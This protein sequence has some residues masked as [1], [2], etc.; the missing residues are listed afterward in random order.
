MESE[1]NWDIIRAWVNGK[2][3]MQFDQWNTPAGEYSLIWHLSDELEDYYGVYV[4]RMLEHTCISVPRNLWKE[5]GA[6]IDRQ[7][8][9]G[10][11]VSALTEAEFWRAALG[12]RAQRIIGPAY[13]GFLDEYH[14][15]PA[16]SQG[17]RKLNL[18]DADDEAALR[19]FLAACPPDDWE[20]SAILFKHQSVMGLERNGALVA[21]ASAPA[22][23][24][25]AAEIY[26]V[27]V[28]TL[29]A[30]RGTGAGLAV[31]SALT[32]RIITS[33]PSMLLHYQTLRANLP[34]VAIAQRLGFEELATSLA[35]RLR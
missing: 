21:V 3:G 23:R 19:A 6:A 25:H 12:E 13:Q 34:S 29:P 9:A 35:V 30:A 11:P 18:D 22:R 28:V 17:A 27:G 16:N 5:T 31:V 26:S 14:F 10:R 15:R 4:W 1:Y 20:A 33:Y 8:A 7:L 24:Y 32:E 2:L